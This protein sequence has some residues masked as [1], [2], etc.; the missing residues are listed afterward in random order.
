MLKK[1]LAILCFSLLFA[2]TA[3]AGVQKQ[4]ETG[5]RYKLIYPAFT[6]TNRQAAK[7]VNKDIKILV[8]EARQLLENP[9]YR[10]EATNYR[11]FK[12]T[13]EYV[14]F[15]FTSWNYTGGAHGMYYTRGLVYDKSSGE[16]LP[17]THFAEAVTPEQLRADIADGRVKVFCADLQTPS[18]AP[19]L[20]DARDFRVSED[21]IIAADGRVYLMYQPY[22]L[23]AYAAGVTCVQLP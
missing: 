1:I 14:C 20:P 4:V 16:S 18:A 15:T 11:L 6:F 2:S 3:L 22:E 8:E 19:F 17:Y 5:E 23:D 9:V 10:E 13:D 7:K 21:Y 12:E